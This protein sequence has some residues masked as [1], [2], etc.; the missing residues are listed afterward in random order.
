MR[1]PAI[2]TSTVKTFERSARFGPKAQPFFLA[3]M[4]DGSTK[5][6]RGLNPIETQEFVE[7]HINS[8][9]TRKQAE[10]MVAAINN[11]GTPA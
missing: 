10:I 8:G 2:K 3:K 5:M 4:S 1:A 9:V 11:G 6:L 7:Q